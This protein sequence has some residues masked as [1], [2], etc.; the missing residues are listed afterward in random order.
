M[1]FFMSA[2]C[3]ACI[4]GAR[5]GDENYQDRLD[6]LRTVIDSAMAPLTGLIELLVYKG[7]IT[8][9]EVASYVEFLLSTSSEYGEGESVARAIWLS[10][11]DRVQGSEPATEASPAKPT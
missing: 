3:S 4:S 2:L 8:K 1:Q 9:E 5:I 7:V 11:L 10:L 6:V